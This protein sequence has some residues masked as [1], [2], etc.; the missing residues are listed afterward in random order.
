MKTK[1][2]KGKKAL[3]TQVHVPKNRGKRADK[4]KDEVYD[5]WFEQQVAELPSVGEYLEDD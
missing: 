3:P 5:D 4:F 2:R 1:V